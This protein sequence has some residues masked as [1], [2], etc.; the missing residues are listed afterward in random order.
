VFTAWRPQRRLQIAVVQPHFEADI[1][2]PWWLIWMV[3]IY[4]E[5]GGG[6]GLMGSSNPFLLTLGGRWHDSCALAAFLLFAFTTT[7]L[8]PRLPGGRRTPQVRKNPC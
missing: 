6:P 2:R 5:P 3:V 8:E 7:L 1:Y 4:R